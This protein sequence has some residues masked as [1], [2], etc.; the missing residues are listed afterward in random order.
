[1]FRDLPDVGAGMIFAA[2]DPGSVNAAI[3]VF[4]DH[5]PVFVDDIRTVNG[6][7]DPTALAHALEDMRVQRIVVENVHAMPKQGVSS[8]FKFGMG[9]G[10]IRGVAGALRLPVTLVSPRMW[11]A[12]HSL[13]SEKEA[14]RALAIRKWPEHNRHLDRKKD[15]DRAEALLIGDWYYVRCV[16]DKTAPEIFL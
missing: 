6:M 15:V 3:A 14:A 2:V 8:T 5:T 1:V 13:T 12:Y 16:I 11:K 7:L 10:I 4:H 9:C